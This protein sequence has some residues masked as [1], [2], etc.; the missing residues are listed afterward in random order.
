MKAVLEI[1]DHDLAD[2][3]AQTLTSEG[4]HCDM[5]VEQRDGF[6]WWSLLVPDEEFDN[7]AA[8]VEAIANDNGPE[9]KKFPCPKCGSKKVSAKTVEN[10]TCLSG[11]YISLECRDCGHKWVT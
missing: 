9:L 8:C 5:H 4:F 6:D 3:A 11:F 10:E 1:T 2:R 7:A